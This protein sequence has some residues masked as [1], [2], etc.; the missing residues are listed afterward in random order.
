[1]RLVGVTPS[2]ARTLQICGLL[3]VLDVADQ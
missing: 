1:M 3:E 2:V